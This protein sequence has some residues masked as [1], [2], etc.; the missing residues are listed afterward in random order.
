[1]QIVEFVILFLRTHSVGTKKL[2][3][4]VVMVFV[5]VKWTNKMF[6]LLTKAIHTHIY[7]PVCMKM[8]NLKRYLCD[9]NF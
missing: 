5:V 6:S 1:M 4:L 7:F 9:L 8:K 3:V 2:E